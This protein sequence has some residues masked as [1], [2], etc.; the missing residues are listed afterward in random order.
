VLPSDPFAGDFSFSSGDKEDTQAANEPPLEASKIRW[1][2]SAIVLPCQYLTTQ[3][4]PADSSDSA[5]D[6]ATVTTEA[7]LEDIEKG[8]AS[9]GKTSRRGSGSGSQASAPNWSGETFE[10]QQL[11]GLDDAFVKFQE[12][13]FIRA[14]GELSDQLLRYERF[15][16]PLP[17]SGKGDAYDLVFPSR[18]YSEDRIKKCERCGSHRTFE[19]QLMPQLVTILSESGPLKEKDEELELSWAT[20][21]CYCC[22]ADCESG[23]TEELAVVQYEEV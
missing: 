16:E 15:G 11:S 1:P 17:F 21:W 23:W 7:S 19:L 18:H 6:L 3:D 10:K 14:G 12:R 4:E 22:S 13:V 20:V 8:V 5:K 2:S 9:L